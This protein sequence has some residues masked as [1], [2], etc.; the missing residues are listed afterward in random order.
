MS[1]RPVLP[2]LAAVAGVALL[3]AGCASAPRGGAESVPTAAPDAS[4]SPVDGAVRAPAASGT[5]I[6]GTRIDLADLWTQRALVVQ[7]TAS[8]CTQ[9]RD[10]E[11]AL[12]EVVESYD[13]AVLLVHVALDEPVDDIRAYLDDTGVTGPVL[14]DRQR[15]IWRD[16]TVSEPPVTAVI[17][18]AGG[19]IRMWPSGA[20]GDDLRA[21]LDRVVQRTDAKK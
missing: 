21:A 17:D 12:R 11:P 3:L 15:A 1:R 19:I 20:D 10:A 2:S 18:T 4:F 9:C 13:D 8:W 5:L 6:D 7:F 14:V 16:Y